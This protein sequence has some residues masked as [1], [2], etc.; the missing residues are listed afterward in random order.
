MAGDDAKRI[1][2][3]ST[4]L[5]IAVAAAELV[6]AAGAVHAFLVRSSG[7]AKVVYL[8]A[9]AIGGVVLVD[10]ITSKLVL[11]NG[12]LEVKSASRRRR[13]KVSEIEAVRWEWGVGVYLK[14]TTGG[15]TKMPELGR[16]SQS[17]ANSLRAWHK[18]WKGHEHNDGAGGDHSAD[19][20]H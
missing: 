7:A 14:L 15:W 11:A 20:P 18:R 4:W 10:V 6:L 1:F 12:V 17:L 2:R 9:A 8:M 5:I 16:N 3:A 13:Y 19:E